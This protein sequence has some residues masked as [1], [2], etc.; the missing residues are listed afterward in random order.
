MTGTFKITLPICAC[1]RRLPSTFLLIPMIAYK[2]LK[3]RFPEIVYVNRLLLKIVALFFCVKNDEIN[4]CKGAHFMDVI[5]WRPPYSSKTSC[6][7]AWSESPYLDESFLGRGSV[8]LFWQRSYQKS[9][10]PYRSCPFQNIL[11]SLF[12]Q[13]AINP[14]LTSTHLSSFLHLFLARLA[15]LRWGRQRVR[16]SSAANVILFSL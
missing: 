13:G 14:F 12:G 16:Q 1:A 3:E 4:F 15:T 11:Q 2:L 9:S 8:G 6:W 10:W 7:D 5:N